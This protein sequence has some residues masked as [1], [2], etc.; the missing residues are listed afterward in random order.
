VIVAE[1]PSVLS[2]FVVGAVLLAGC[3][4]AASSPTPSKP[5]PPGASSGTPAS[6]S[7]PANGA[8]TKLVSTYAVV[9]KDDLPLWVAKDAGIFEKNGL[10]VDLQLSANGA[11]VMAALVSGKTQVA[12]TGGSDAVNAAAGGAEVVVVDV[13]TPNY[14]YQL[15][16]TGDIKTP[17]DLKGK[18]IGISAF[19]SSDHIALLVAWPKLGIDPAKDVSFI[20]VGGPSTRAA[21][22]MSGAIQGDMT[23][24]P[25]SLEL[26]KK[27]FHELF[28]LAALGYPAVMQ[29]AIVQRSYL[30]ANRGTVQKYVDSMVQA[31][32][33]MKQ[34]KPLSVKLLEKYFKSDDEEAM[35][36]TYDYFANKVVAPLP[37]P[38]PE[39]FHDSIE[40]FGKSN[41][42]MANFDVSR[43]I[44][45]SLVQSAADR[46]LNVAS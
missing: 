25:N 36:A 17:A 41:Q 37:Y 5:A 19:G 10:D 29:S 42:N 13:T 46:K 2:T 33:R 7:A 6:A 30:S 3:G 35:S 44:D 18:K 38:K 26:D 45:Q 28:D 1:L 9:A 24:P 14:A 8:L 15:Y 39:L 23:S 16:V 32:V 4:T 43:I 21:A 11:A 34:D 40:E 12:Q 31:I 27:G 22:M 20:Q